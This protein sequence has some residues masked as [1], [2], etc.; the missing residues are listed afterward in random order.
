MDRISLA[1]YSFNGLHR[2]GMID[3]FGYLETLKYRYNLHYA[4]IWNGLFVEYGDEYL[5][6]IREM[7]DEKG[8][9]VASLCCDWAHPWDDDLAVRAK[10]DETAQ[11]C[12]KAAE[13]L[14]SKTVRFDVGVRSEDITEEQYDLIV[15]KFTEYAQRGY[16][17]GYMVGPENHWG[18]SRK[19]SVQKELYKRVKNPGYGILLHLGNW[20]LEEGCTIESNN[21]AAA[22]MAVHSHVSYDYARE[23]VELLPQLRE[24]G[25]KGVWGLEH[26]SG[27]DEYTKVEVHLGLLR[28]AH[29]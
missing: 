11:N 4:D 1:S 16:D 2:R 23:A 20:I 5:K 24:A 17:H 25:Y 26:H 3:A 8:L 12:L 10:N 27:V 19:I 7:L 28:L 9:E 6:K 22:P 15:K 29:C 13:I 18:A 14:G 21:L